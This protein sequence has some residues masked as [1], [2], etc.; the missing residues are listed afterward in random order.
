MAFNLSEVLKDV[1]MPDTNRERFAYL[2]Y[3]SLLP[4]PTNGYSMDGVEELARNIELVGLQQPLRVKELGADAYGLISGHRRHAAIGLI[5]QRDPG[6]FSD[7]IPCVIDAAGGSVAMRELQLL[8]ANADNRKMTAA[9]EAQQAE[10]ISDCLRRLEDEGYKFP[11]RHR[12]WV[13]KLSGLSRTK[14]GRLEAINR[15]LSPVWKKLFDD[16]KLGET[17]AYALQKLPAARQ[18]LLYSLCINAKPRVQPASLIELNVNSFAKGCAN[19]D[20]RV[21]HLDGSEE[22][23]SWKTELLT[24]GYSRPGWVTHYGAC[25]N[26]HDCARCCAVC[27]RLTVCARVCPKLKGKAAEQARE[28]EQKEAERKKRLQADMEEN[29][30]READ[31]RKAREAAETTEWKRI[32]ARR[33]A[34][35]LSCEEAYQ[36]GGLDGDD[37]ADIEARENGELTGESFWDTVWCDDYDELCGLA[38]RLQCSV[39]WL[40]GRVDTPQPVPSPDTTPAWPTGNPTKEGTNAAKLEPGS[41]ILLTLTRWKNGAWHLMSTDAPVLLSCL[42]WYPL[43]EEG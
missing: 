31:K 30:Q 42:A 12:D 32:G 27:D 26:Y 28:K 29:R 16:G 14:I 4:D 20:N 9:D 21:C 11:G 17:V 23:C 15:N 37:V 5:L 36:I 35:G 33:R 34:L 8:L 19:A 2:P 3:A 24:E 38:D 18:D 10:R 7:G 22:P 25:S 39:D 41:G 40:L 43:P 1:S 13:S 6:A